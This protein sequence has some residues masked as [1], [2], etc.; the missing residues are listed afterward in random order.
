MSRQ[1]FSGVFRWVETGKDVW[2]LEDDP[3]HFRGFV[4]PIAGDNYSWFVTGGPSFSESCTWKSGTTWVMCGESPTRKAAKLEVESVV[5][6]IHR[7][8]LS[9]TFGGHEYALFEFEDGSPVVMAV[10]SGAHCEHYLKPGGL[11]VRVSAYQNR[12]PRKAVA[13]V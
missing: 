11:I 8:C 1:T 5:F 6:A 7:Y 2:G 9:T 10:G 13:H 12:K 4:L 3:K